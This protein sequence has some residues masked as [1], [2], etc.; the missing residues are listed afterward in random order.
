MRDLTIDVSR[1][2]EERLNILCEMVERW[3]PSIN[4]IA[5]SSLPQLWQR[6]IRDSAQVV[7]LIPPGARLW[8]DIG[9]GGGFPGLVV[10]ACLPEVFPACRVV[11]IESDQRK[12]V[13]LRQAARSMGLSIT[14]IAQRIEEAPPQAADVV[15]ARALAPLPRLL[16]LTQRHLAPHGIAILLKG[17]S[18]ADELDIAG[19]NGWKFQADHHKSKTDPDGTI[20]VMRNLKLEQLS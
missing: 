5:P 16:P 6:H 15:S 1:E 19:Q 2:T 18:L 7:A 17:Q 10:A 12:C 3:N 9:S 11:L 8:V 14:V 13:F 20:I 4:L